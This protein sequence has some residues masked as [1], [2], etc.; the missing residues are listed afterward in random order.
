MEGYH[1]NENS[2]IPFASTLSDYDNE[3]TLISFAGTL[4]FL[5]LSLPLSFSHA[6]F[7]FSPLTWGKICYEKL[8]NGLYK[9]AEVDLRLK[10]KAPW[11]WGLIHA[12]Y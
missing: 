1:D 8:W 2:L 10:A 9:W 3:N 6:L 4:F 12:S 7:C 11:S 5:S